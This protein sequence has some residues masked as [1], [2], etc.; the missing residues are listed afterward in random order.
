MT[1]DRFSEL[2]VAR[3]RLVILAAVAAVLALAYGGRFLSFHADTREFFSRENPLVLALEV[4]E[5]TF[6]KEDHLMFVL[7]PAD[8]NVFTRETLA[9]V[10]ELT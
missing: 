6:A 5:N 4:H 7:A 3:R 9:A 1:V 10:E 8:G 2:I